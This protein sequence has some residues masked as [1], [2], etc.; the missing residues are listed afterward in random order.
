MLALYGQVVRL[1]G[2][3]TAFRPVAIIQDLAEATPAS[4]A[5]ALTA[6]QRGEFNS[7][8]IGPEAAGLSWVVRPRL[9]CA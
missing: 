1:T 6:R 5:N 7:F 9:R 8:V 4:L 2:E 3:Q